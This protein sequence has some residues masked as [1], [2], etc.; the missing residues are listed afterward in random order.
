MLKNITHLIVECYTIHSFKS[1]QD[2]CRE[3]I[4]HGFAG[5]SG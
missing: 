1:M 3:G 4:C 5:I 2:I